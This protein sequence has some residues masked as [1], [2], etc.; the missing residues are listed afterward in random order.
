M[1]FAFRYLEI[2]T[3]F[4]HTDQ[5]KPSP[6]GRFH[7]SLEPTPA[8]T[9]ILGFILFTALGILGAGRILRLAFPAASFALS[10]FLYQ[11]YP[12]LYM[13]FTWWI[14]F[15][16]PLVRRLIDWR[17]GYENQSIILMTPFL[18][19]LAC[20]PNFFQYL[21]KFYPY[22]QGGLPFIF[23]FVGIVYSFALGLASMLTTG[24]NILLIR[25]F[26]EWIAP[27]IFG[28]Y[29][30]SNWQNYPEYRQN[31]QRNFF[32]G[33][34]VLGIYGLVQFCLLPPW[35]LL[36]QENVLELG[37]GN[38]GTP[39]PFELSVWSTLNTPGHLAS[40]MIPCL[41][42]LFNSKQVL[43]IPATVTGILNLLLANN[44]SSWGG[45]L[46]GCFVL[47]SKLKPH[48]QIR[49]IMTA[50]VIILLVFPL[51]TMEPFSSKIT[52]RVQSI[53][54]VEEDA[55]FGARKSVYNALLDK[56]LINPRGYGM[57]SLSLADSGLLVVFFEMGWLGSIFY[58]GGYIF[59]FLNLFQNSQKSRADSFIVAARAAS[60]GLFIVVPMGN[61]LTAL[62]GTLIWSFASIVMAGHKYYHYQ[63]SNLS[64]KQ[65]N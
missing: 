6:K 50:L 54:N 19:T 64:I 42:L 17:V 28:F 31:I 26:I 61:I 63:P 14:W 3:I 9:A 2:M 40:V 38:V 8:W 62:P 48:I 44:R 5:T 11:R 39:A 29:I 7:L 35:D 4:P 25:L 51:A 13:G 56:A 58:A 46:V 34:L 22:R 49:V 33:A 18:V 65:T 23:A 24:F 57:G 37:Y 32:W 10:I 16:T 15:L 55:S 43:S 21:L 36:W 1:S 59:L 27:I 60:F 53:S 45:F 20:F 12:L 47:I 30:F 52:D 41:L